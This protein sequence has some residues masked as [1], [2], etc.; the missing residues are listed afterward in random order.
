MQIKTLNLSLIR[1]TATYRSGGRTDGNRAA[2]TGKDAVPGQLIQ[3][4][5]KRVAEANLELGKK[6]SSGPTAKGTW[7]GVEAGTSAS[8]SPTIVIPVSAQLRLPSLLAILSL[9]SRSP[10]P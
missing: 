1:T 3:S 5:T 2:S 10:M 4:V 6:S 9:H 8:F 7:L